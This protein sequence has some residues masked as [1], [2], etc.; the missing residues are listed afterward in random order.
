LTAEE[1]DKGQRNGTGSEENLKETDIFTGN[2][3]VLFSNLIITTSKFKAQLV[4]HI[5]ERE[6]VTTRS[7]H[8]IFAISYLHSWTGLVNNPKSSHLLLPERG[9]S[10]IFDF[11]VRSFSFFV[12]WGII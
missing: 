11:A 3:R 6:T 4:L 8:T 5:G 9:P 7:K 12:Q 10:S 1:R 2:S